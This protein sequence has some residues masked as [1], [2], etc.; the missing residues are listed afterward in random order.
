MS[1][2]SSLCAHA[3]ARLI[4]AKSPAGQ[5]FARQSGLMAEVRFPHSP[6][7]RSRTAAV[8]NTRSILSTRRRKRWS[9]TQSGTDTAADAAARTASSFAKRKRPPP[10]PLAIASAA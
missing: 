8:W 2:A 9:S 5:P 6:L 1:V 10:P 4:K 3:L 7:S